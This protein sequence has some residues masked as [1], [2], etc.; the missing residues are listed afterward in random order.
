MQRRVL[1][2][3][4]EYIRNVGELSDEHLDEFIDYVENWYIEC[5]EEKRKRSSDLNTKIELILIDGG[6]ED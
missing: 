4:E 2:L 6:G 3:V 1:T 5:T